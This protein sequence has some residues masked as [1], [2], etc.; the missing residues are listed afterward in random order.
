MY[1]MCV[2]AGLGV[3][4]NLRV[5]IRD[6]HCYAHFC[7]KSNGAARVLDSLGNFCH[8]NPSTGGQIIT[9]S[10]YTTLCF[11]LTIITESPGFLLFFDNHINLWYLVIVLRVHLCY[12]GI[13]WWSLVTVIPIET[14]WQRVVGLMILWR[15]GETWTDAD[16]RQW[17]AVRQDRYFTTKPVLKS[18]KSSGELPP[19]VLAKAGLVAVTLTLVCLTF[20]RPRLKCLNQAKEL[21]VPRSII[22]SFRNTE[23]YGILN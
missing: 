15:D 12:S 5:H 14:Q 16:I 9:V 11:L 22:W 10:G 18:H 8:S 23:L 6:S 2:W 1:C 13:M 4:A 7:F 21:G 3:V 19:Q 20:F 17:D